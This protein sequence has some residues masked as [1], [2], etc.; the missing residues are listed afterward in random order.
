[1][2]TI[3]IITKREIKSFFNSLMAYLII[4]AFL[5]LTGLF[6]WLVGQPVFFMKEASLIS[7]FRISYLALFILPA[8]LTMGAI[9]E[10]NSS[11]TLE[12]ILTKPVTDLQLVLGKFIAGVILVALALVLTIPYYI[13]VANI[14]NIDHGATIMGYFGLLLMSAAYISIGI[15]ASSLAKNQIVAL[16]L[17]LFIGIFFQYIF[18]IASNYFPGT[19]GNLLNYLSVSSHFQSIIRGV[20]DSRDIIYFASIIALGLFGAEIV[21]SKRN[22][23]D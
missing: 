1:M 18:S 5:V 11:G 21:I 6:T 8:A 7:F 15:F 9:A 3:W 19:I 17:A 20:V 16:L 23:T 10:E 2:S 4:I 14:G 22:L 13:T 12:F